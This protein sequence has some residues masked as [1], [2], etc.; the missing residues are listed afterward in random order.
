[1][2]D[3]QAEIDR[4]V[5]P[6][7]QRLRA[8]R[9]GRLLVDTRHAHLYFP[10]ERRPR[11]AVPADDLAAPVPGAPEHAGLVALAPDDADLWVEEDSPTYGAPRNPYHRVDTLASSRR[12]EVH[13]GHVV[14]A[15]TTRPVLLIDRRATPLV[16]APGAIAWQHLE[17]NP[18][19]TLCQYKGEATYWRVLGTEVRLWSYQH[20][21]PEVAPIAGHL[22]GPRRT[23][24]RADHHRR[25][26]RGEPVTT[27]DDPATR[28]A[29]FWALADTLLADEAI[30]RSTMMGYPCLRAN[31]AFFACV[32]RGTG[33]LVVK[34]P[35]PR[36]QELVAS[37]QALPFAPNGRMFR[38]WA[39]FPVPDRDEWK[40]LLDEA[41]T[42]VNA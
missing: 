36:V 10:D 4:G 26:S 42:F 20:P 32:E 11:W 30:E 41:K 16:R 9:D 31:G 1:M 24:R 39:A 17:P 15:E 34:L 29:L 21:D 6:V 23:P 35:A 12:I 33:N 22:A 14:V 25:P 19:T 18:A 40:A 37:G 13:V 27:T 3:N 2:P 28:E 8:W 7:H 38:E 5:E